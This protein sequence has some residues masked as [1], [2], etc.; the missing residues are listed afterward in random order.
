MSYLAE[1]RE[2]EKERR[3][4]DIIEAA[5]RLYA[6]HGW[7]TLTME[8]VGRE[9]R[10]SRALLYVYFRDKEDLLL[11]ITVRALEDLRERFEAAETDESQGIEQV[12]AMGEAYARFAAER[13]FRY[14]ACARFHAHQLHPAAGNE[15]ACIEQGD[16]V[17]AVMVRAIERGMADGSIRRDLGDPLRACFMLWSFS[18]GL[19]Q[20]ATNKGEEMRRHGIEASGLMADGHAWLRYLLEPRD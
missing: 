8:Q 5:E 13:P 1:R 15:C 19:L 14:D 17:W 20:I 4:L 18:H 10:V 3:R 12:A 7:D 11:A 16:A 6:A 9:A 2:E